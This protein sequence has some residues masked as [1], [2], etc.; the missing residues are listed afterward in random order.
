GTYNGAVVEG[1]PQG[2]YVLNITAD[3]AWTVT[4]SQPRDVA[5]A[6]LP[7]TYSGAGQQVVGPFSAGTSVRMQSQNTATNGGNF[8]VEI[9]ASDGSLQD[10]PFNSIG[11][12]SGSAI[13]NDLVGGPYWLNV[14]SEGNWTITVSNVTSPASTPT[15]SARAT[16]KV[17]SST[18]GVTNRVVTAASHSL[19]FTGPG[20]SLKTATIIGAVLMLLGL[21]MLLLADFPRRMVN[22]LAY[23]TPR[24]RK[25]GGRPETSSTH[26]DLPIEHGTAS[27]FAEGW[28]VDPFAAHEERLFKQGIATPVVRDGGVSSYDEPP[29][30]HA[31]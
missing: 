23:A 19:A 31:G 7:Q 16:T 30:F 21:L 17:T 11:S 27:H 6:A 15:T 26:G 3:A 28:Y 25:S 20:P 2:N 9:L 24:R 1:L 13:S 10:I 22:Q 29:G 14:D 12:F 8:I 4:V 18:S 5:G